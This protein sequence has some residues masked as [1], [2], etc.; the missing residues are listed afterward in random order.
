MKKKI[1]NRR[2]EQEKGMKI[3]SDRTSEEGSALS[4]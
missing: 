3:S 2:G 4:G 1:T